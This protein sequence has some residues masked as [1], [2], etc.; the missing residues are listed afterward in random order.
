MSKPKIMTV[1]GTRPEAIKVAPVIK[2]LEK[3]ERFESVA[4]STGQHREMLEQVN[5]MFGIEPKLDLH[6]MKPG[7]SLNEIV[8]RALKGLDEIIDSEKPDVIISQGDTSTAMAAALAGFHRGV[9]IVHLEAGLRTGD[10]HSPFPEEANRKLIGQVAELHLAPT[11]GSMENL[12]RENVRSKDI[13]VTGNTVIDAL[14][15][16]ASW[17]TEFEDSALQGAAASD[18]RLVVVTTHRRENLEAM[19][20]I[21]GA[22]KDL[23][24]AYPDINFALPLHLNPKVREA[25]LPEVESLPNVIITDPLPYDQFT[26]LLDRATIILTD[27]GG[28]QEEAPALGKPVLVMRQNTERPE[29]VVA[30]TVKLVGTNRSLIVAEAKLLLDDSAAYDA[31]ANAVNPYGDGKGAER[32]VAAI[33]ELLGVG[34]R[35]PDFAPDIEA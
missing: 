14:L 5:T 31:M 29:A 13:A 30:G 17:D 35:L 24:E 10:I 2:A 22:V 20:E 1:Y 19:K 27:S 9:K 15:E 33:A 28:V 12:R 32:A 21:G 18:K 23:A 8:S 16:A 26:K 6:L 3:D 7:Q 4:V 11:A 34:E 25:V